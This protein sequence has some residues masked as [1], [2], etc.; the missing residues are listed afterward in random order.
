MVW[1][2]SSMSY[3]WFGDA[4]TSASSA[5]SSRSSGSSVGCARRIVEVVAGHERQQLADERDALGVVLD[6]EMRDA[7]LLVVRHRAAELFLGDVLVRHRL[8]H[9]G[10]G[11]E[12]VARLLHHDDEVGDRRRV[13]GAAGAGA[14][15]RGDLRHHARGE[16]VAE[17]D[18][19]VAAERDD[20]FL[21]ARAA[22]VVQADDRRAVAHR[23]V[24]H[25][26]DLGGVGF[27]QRA[28]EHGEVLRE[29]VDHA[30]VDAAVAADHAVAGDDLLLHP[31]V[32]AAVGDELVHF[33][34][35]ARIEQARHAL[36]RGQLACVVLLLEPLFAAAELGEPLAFAAVVRW[37]P[38]AGDAGV[39]TSVPTPCHLHHHAIAGRQRADARRRAGGNDVA[40]IQ[41]HEPRDV[42]D[43][44]R[45][46]EDQ[47]ARVGVVT[48]LAVHPA[49]DVEL[50]RIEADGNAR[51]DR[52]RT[53]R[54]P[55]RANT[56]RPSP[57]A[58]AR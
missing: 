5:S 58:R 32:L 12:H 6:G 57:A 36:A 48:P 17:E 11:D 56:A 49:F 41:R 51:P 7:A 33:L 23:H 29:G 13:D 46:R 25:L 15:D 16:R 24:H 1:I 35:R 20:A 30:A 38:S 8:D 39:A 26:A 55:W 47:L 28:A 50:R 4:G 52:R 45:H 19:G 42:L 37:D 10:A 43:Q 44:V 2:R 21:D 31:E 3:G 54:S 14:H 27:R 9:V 18:V 22:G 40:R 34:E 53:C